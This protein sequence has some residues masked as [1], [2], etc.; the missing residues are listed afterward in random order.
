MPQLCECEKLSEMTPS[1]RAGCK[2]AL[3]WGLQQPLLGSSV[4]AQRRQGEAGRGYAAMGVHAGQ[5]WQ[6]TNGSAGSTDSLDGGWCLACPLAVDVVGALPGAA[7]RLT[8]FLSGLGSLNVQTMTFVV[9]CGPEETHTTLHWGDGVRGL[10]NR[11]PGAAQ[12]GDGCAAWKAGLHNPVLCR[13]QERFL[14]TD[15]VPERNLGPPAAARWRWAGWWGLSC[16]W[17]DSVQK[18]RL[19]WK[20]LSRAW[21]H[22]VPLW[23]LRVGTRPGTTRTLA[24]TRPGVD[25]EVEN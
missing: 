22:P 15:K 12:S 25:E 8:P 21:G 9:V 4:S 5:L 24:S 20:R 23:G 3:V 13:E 11:L 18:A 10:T 2:V 7:Q 1:S 14:K 17:M 6:L 16:S 19:L